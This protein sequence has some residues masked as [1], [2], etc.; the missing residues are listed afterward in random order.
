MNQQPSNQ[1]TGVFKAKGGVCFDLDVN[2]FTQPDVREKTKPQ[3]APP[4]K[5]KK[6][7]TK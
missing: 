7:N 1:N 5:A 3:P 4:K 6:A 2:Q